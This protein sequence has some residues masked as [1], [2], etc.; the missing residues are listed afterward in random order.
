MQAG[1]A[2]CLPSPPPSPFLVSPLRSP[3]RAM[4][5]ARYPAGQRADRRDQLPRDLISEV[6]SASDNL[7]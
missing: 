1:V 7:C 3:Q 5:H 4:L 6:I 2:F